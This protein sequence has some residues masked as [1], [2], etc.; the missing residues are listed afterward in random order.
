LADALHAHP[1][2]KGVAV[3][4]HNTLEGYFH[5]HRFASAY[6]DVV[7]IPGVEVTTVLGDVIVLGVKEKPAYW[8]SLESVIDFV[9]RRNGVIVVPHPYRGG[10]IRD[11]AK[12]IPNGLGAVEVLNPDS[13]P[14]ENNMADMLAKTGNLPGVAGSDAHH[15]QQMWKAYTQIDADSNVESILEAIKTGRVKAVLAKG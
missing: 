12:K 10:G 1:F 8:S 6:E 7:I 9:R 3:T 15:V 2:I 4:D 5:V 13:T 11:A 14:E